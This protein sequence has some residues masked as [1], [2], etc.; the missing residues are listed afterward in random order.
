MK[1]MIMSMIINV[2]LLGCVNAQPNENERY[3]V[4]DRVSQEV[5]DLVK[6]YE[7]IDSDNIIVEV[8]SLKGDTI[9]S[10]Y[11]ASLYKV[12]EVKEL[13]GEW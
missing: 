1:K 7:Y 12:V 2:F 9:Y 13:S 11:P 4:I 6:E 3:A 10:K 5:V 8:V